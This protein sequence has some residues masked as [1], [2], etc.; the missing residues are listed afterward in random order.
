MYLRRYE[1]VSDYEE[2]SD[3]ESESKVSDNQSTNT[4]EDMVRPDKLDR[5]LIIRLQKI[6]PDLIEETKKLEKEVLFIQPDNLA[7]VRE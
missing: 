3:S 2:M 1:T 6:E 5:K 7:V 4:D